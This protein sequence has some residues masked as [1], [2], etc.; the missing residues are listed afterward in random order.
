MCDCM[1]QTF[2]ERQKIIQYILKN[3]VLSQKLRRSPSVL[4]SCSKLTHVAL[5][6]SIAY[7]TY[8]ATQILSPLA[9]NVVYTYNGKYIHLPYVCVC[10]YIYT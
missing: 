8:S 10:V 7:N 9:S 2:T 1:L 6:K 3:A 5:I 4:A